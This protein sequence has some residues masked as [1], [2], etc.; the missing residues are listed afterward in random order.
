MNYDSFFNNWDK[1]FNSSAFKTI[2]DFQRNAQEIS[3]LVNP[4]AIAAM[5]ELQKNSHI[6]SKLTNP[7]A[8]AAMSEIQ[9]NSQVISGFVNSPASSIIKNQQSLWNSALSFNNA[10]KAAD[11]ATLRNQAL[12]KNP[13]TQNQLYEIKTILEPSKTLFSAIKSNDT[14]F[15]AFNN[16]G[17]FST[18]S[19]ISKNMTAI[20][21]ISKLN[22]LASILEPLNYVVKF[23]ND[24]DILVDDEILSKDEILEFAK[25]FENLPLDNSNSENII[26]KIKSKK[27]TFFIHLIWII[28]FKLLFSPIVEDFFSAIRDKT[29]ISTIIEELDIKGWVDELWKNNLNELILDN[30]PIKEHEDIENQVLPD[31]VGEKSIPEQS[32]ND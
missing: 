26:K 18:I 2:N 25:E 16:S 15:K 14:I 21:A 17:I 32:D 30:L 7:P 12:Y 8:I 5:N 27:G 6:I 10:L 3:H 4:P 31:T 11:M 13:F 19:Y 28:L 20:T 9:R 23:S 1:I 22:S 24:N 29:G